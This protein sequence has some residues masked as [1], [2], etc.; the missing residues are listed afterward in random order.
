M[1]VKQPIFPASGGGCMGEEGMGSRITESA[2]S[3]IDRHDDSDDY[4]LL[5]PSGVAHCSKCLICSKLH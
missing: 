3:G 4:C 1:R 2:A 5:R